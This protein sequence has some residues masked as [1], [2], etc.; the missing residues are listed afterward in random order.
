MLLEVEVV[1]VDTDK[2]DQIAAEFVRNM[3]ELFAADT[4]L[5]FARV[6]N[7]G[8]QLAAQFR[9]AAREVDSAYDTDPANPQVFV[10]TDTFPI[11][12]TTE[13]AK[14]PQQ[15]QNPMTAIRQVAL[16]SKL[17]YESI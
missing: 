10:L 12:R 11:A 7:A 4:R 15:Y 2:G 8:I 9:K 16:T 1:R 3:N 17:L 5:I 14:N 6:A 13:Q